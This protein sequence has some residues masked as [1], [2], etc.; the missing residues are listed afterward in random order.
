MRRFLALALIPLLAGCLSIPEGAFVTTSD[1][2]P[3]VKV[4]AWAEELDLQIR[5]G[6]AMEQ[7]SGTFQYFVSGEGQRP[8]NLTILDEAG[9]PVLYQDSPMY[10]DFF[11]DS[12]ANGDYKE[13]RF[14]WDFKVYNSS[15]AS[16]SDSPQPYTWAPLGNYTAVIQFHFRGVLEDAF[17]VAVPFEIRATYATSSQ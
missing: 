17:E 2:I 5:F 6:A 14:T 16:H 11:Y 15:R 1:E 3:G 7:D 4:S 10:R 12:V 8:W 9:E 13:F